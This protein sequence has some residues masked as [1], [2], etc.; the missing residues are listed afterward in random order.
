MASDDPMSK[1]PRE[2]VVRARECADGNAAALRAEQQEN[3]RLGGALRACV[4]SATEGSNRPNNCDHC[5]D[6]VW[7]GE[8][9][10]APPPNEKGGSPTGGHSLGCPSE[11]P[12]GREE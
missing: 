5:C 1:T 2:H 4:K 7:E 9:A 11:T 10:L 12:K 8:R 3:E 6:V